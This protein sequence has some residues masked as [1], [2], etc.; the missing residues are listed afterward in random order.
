MGIILWMLLQSNCKCYSPK[1]NP[2]TSWFLCTIYQ[3]INYYNSYLLCLGYCT[4]YRPK[5]QCSS[6]WV[7]LKRWGI[8]LGSFLLAKHR[9]QSKMTSKFP[10]IWV[11]GLFSFSNFSSVTIGSKISSV[12]VFFPD[13]FN[14]NVKHKKTFSLFRL[15]SMTT[16]FDSPKMQITLY[17]TLC[18][19]CSCSFKC[20]YWQW[21]R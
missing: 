3:F 21:G 10:W 20:K 13:C 14:I 19:S 11:K 17:F 4:S 8:T 6:W 7:Q 2:V 5:K 1:Q 12:F 16:G 15:H 9:K 18:I